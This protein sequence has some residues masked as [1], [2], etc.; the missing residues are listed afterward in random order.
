MMRG[1][2]S[3]PRT[4][5]GGHLPAIPPE[6][7]A[8]RE[9][10]R[11]GVT[12]LNRFRPPGN[13]ALLRT[14]RLRPLQ[15]SMRQCLCTRHMPV[16]AARPHFS[17]VLRIRRALVRAGPHPSELHLANRLQ[18][19]DQQD[20]CRR[21]STRTDRRCNQRCTAD[22]PFCAAGRLHGANHLFEVDLKSRSAEFD[23]LQA[24]HAVHAV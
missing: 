1:D 21:A 18:R 9:L 23:P 19:G 2:A 17:W 15:P 12:S 16:F 24:R 8:A 13:G 14:W 4:G 22:P 10:P 20:S 7:I 11:K 3:P 6:V 5:A